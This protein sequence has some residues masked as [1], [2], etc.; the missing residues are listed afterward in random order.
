VTY[1]QLHSA[2]RSRFQNL[3]AQ[4][5]ALPTIYDNDPTSPPAAGTAWC[6]FTILDGQSRQTVCGVTEYRLIG[7]AIAQLFGP[8][9]RGDTALQR[10][11]DAIIGAFRGRTAAGVR[12][13]D[14]Y[15]QRVGLTDEGDC[16]QVNVVCPFQADTQES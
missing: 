8:A 15:E 5:L 16:Y 10:K 14:A 9:G 13:G 7:V 12:Y 1:E 6:R 3:I 2:I 4:V 11:V